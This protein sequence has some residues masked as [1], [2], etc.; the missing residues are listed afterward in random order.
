MVYVALLRGIN[1][2]GKAMVSMTALKSCF[3]DL[4][5]EDVTTYI[6]SGNVLFKTDRVGNGTMTKEIEAALQET[7]K[8]NVKVLLKTEPQLKE[9]LSKVPAKWVNDVTTKCDVMF[10]WPE[11]DKPDVIEQLTVNPDVEELRYEPGALLWCLERANYTKSRVP[12]MIGTPLYA[13]MTIRNINTLRKLV[14][15]AD[16]L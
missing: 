2:G 9:L 10:L 16:K 3:E 8:L 7:F 11:I 14:A 6:N 1:V 5:F 4:G 12:R 15:L 13:Q